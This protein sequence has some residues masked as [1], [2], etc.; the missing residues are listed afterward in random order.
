[1]SSLSSAGS[2]SRNLPSRRACLTSSKPIFF[3]IGV[4]FRN[5]FAGGDD[6]TA[7]GALELLGPVECFGG[8][9]LLGHGVQVGNPGGNGALFDGN[10]VLHVGAIRQ[11]L[12][13]AV[14]TIELVILDAH[15]SSSFG[16]STRELASR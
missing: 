13:S 11:S 16:T 14:I 10:Q 5:D 6:H 7:L 4:C 8:D 1:M 12:I 15:F 3:S 9:D 2:R